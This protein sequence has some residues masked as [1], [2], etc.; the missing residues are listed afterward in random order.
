MN[1]TVDTLNAH[2]GDRGTQAPP[3]DADIATIPPQVLH[4]QVAST[5]SSRTHRKEPA[6][7]RIVVGRIP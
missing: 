1:G 6:S 7:G 2:R 4:Q 5:V 3:G